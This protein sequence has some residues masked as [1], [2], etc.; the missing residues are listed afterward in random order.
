VAKKQIKKTPPTRPWRGLVLKL[1]LVL[2]IAMAA[3]IVYLD[4]QIKHSFSGNKWQVPAQ[5]FARPMHLVQGEEVTRKEV[6]DELTLLGYRRVNNANSSGEYSIEPGTIVIVRRGFQFPDG[7]ED[8]RHL[9]V[10]W[11]GSRIQRIEDIDTQD[12]LKEVRLEPWLVTRMVSSSRED[13][14]LVSLNDVP[15]L[16]TKALTLVED[17]DFYTHYGVAPLSILR[18]LIANISAGKTV[19]GGSTLT[20][21][22]VKNLYLTNERSIIRKI[23]EALMALI[24][25]ARYSKEEIIQAYLNEVFLGQNG[26]MAV[27]GFGLAS[28]FY[29]DRPIYELELTEVALLVGM[30]KGPSYYSPRSHPERALE[31]RNLVLRIL[32]EANEL[33]PEQY[34]MAVAAPLGL[35]TG[36]SLASG[37]HPAFMD[38]VRRELQEILADPDIRESGVKVFTTLDI[39]AQR[40]AEEA[41]KTTLTS[42]QKSREVALEAAMVVTDTQNG[43]VRAIVGGKRT[44]FKGFNRALDARRPIGSLVKPAVYLTALEQ[45]ELYNLATPIIDEPISLKSTNGQLWEP[46]NADKKFRGQVPLVTALTKSLNVPTVNLGMALGLDN[47]A[48]TLTRLGIKQ[49]INPVPALTLG[50]ISLSPFSTSQMY[51]TIANN[52]LY[53]PLH[54]VSAVVSPS[55]RLMWL[56]ADYMEQRV[57]EE[58]T[59]LVNY[60]LYKVTQEGTGRLVGQSFPQINMAGKTGTTD[61]YRDSWFAGFDRQHLVTVWVGNDDNEPINLSGAKG[62][63]PIFIAYQKSQEPKSL[64]RRFPAGLGIAHFDK[65]TGAVVIAGC[66]NSLSVPAVLDVLPA[67]AQNCAGQPIEEVHEEKKS[68]WERLFGS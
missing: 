30:I 29:F 54:T 5:I 28:Y 64:S 16:L 68:W 7:F 10:T 58:A 21:Q 17:R 67:P 44:E 50:A 61:D 52:G 41:L 6:L 32:L 23:K 48:Y 37:R 59:Y 46:Q 55:H 11:S 66:P 14:M 13:R 35:A 34:E 24:I 38:K 1:L 47:I 33:T 2:S 19:Q 51:Q 65:N 31:R 15:K 20:Q 27:H 49:E 18:A 39:H 43:E 22:L 62:A 53:R 60:S 4:A 63:L 26:E 40:R 42:L 25:D 56:H 12:T 8:L 36:D 57:L 45:P 3:Y 9:K